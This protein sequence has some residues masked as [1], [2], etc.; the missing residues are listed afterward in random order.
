MSTHL[1]SPH[2]GPVEARASLIPL[3]LMFDADDTLWENNIYFERA[4]ERFIGFLAH[5]TMTPS[6]VRDAF[7]RL[8]TVRVKT[9]GYGC[10]AFHQSLV[11]GFEHLTGAP[12]EAQHVAE[13]AACAAGIRDADIALLP[14]VAETLPVLAERHTLILVTKGDHEEQTAKLQR[15]G[16]EQYFRHVEVLHEK[17]TSAY[18]QLL[19]RYRLDPAQTWMIGNSPR[20]DANPALRAGMHAAYLP[21]PSTWVLEEEAITEPAPGRQ[22]L[23]LEGF[24]ELLSHFG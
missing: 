10:N 12:C 8:E 16:L 15:S 7:D 20:S 9:H 1:T 23:H 2:S 4:I 5:P 6:E 3:T 24:A 14:G 22:L 11:A 13:L 17:H 18:L 19:E 21:H